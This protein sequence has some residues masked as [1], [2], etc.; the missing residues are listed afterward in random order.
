MREEIRGVGIFLHTLIMQKLAQVKIEAEREN[1][2]NGL[3]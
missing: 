1:I 2:M 3:N